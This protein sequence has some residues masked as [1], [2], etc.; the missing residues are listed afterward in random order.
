MSNENDTPDVKAEITDSTGVSATI[1]SSTEAGGTSPVDD[2]AAASSKHAQTAAMRQALDEKNK[3]GIGDRQLKSVAAH[4]TSV[5]ELDLDEMNTLVVK[6]GGRLWR[7]K[8]QTIGDQKLMTQLATRSDRQADEMTQAEQAE[9]ALSSLYPQVAKV[10]EDVETGEPP[11]REF[12]EEK[13]TTRNFGRL[14]ERLN[15]DSA[16]GNPMAG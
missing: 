15:T 1:G 9:V 8:E 11:T 6:L 2:A 12:V 16:E 5:A 13:L 7:A 3:A 4:P 14:M 10:L